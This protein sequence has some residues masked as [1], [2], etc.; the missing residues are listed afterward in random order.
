MDADDYD[1]AGLV[2]SLMKYSNHTI[3]DARV[4]QWSN[5]LF[6]HNEARRWKI[7]KWM[8][9][10]GMIVP[11]DGP[12]RREFPQ[13]TPYLEPFHADEKL[14]MF[15]L[16]DHGV[17]AYRIGLQ[18]FLRERDKIEAAPYRASIAAV[19]GFWVS[20]AALALSLI[21]IAISIIAL[22]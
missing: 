17:E 20:I 3:S 9:G 18:L 10:K 14:H 7:Y 2:L 8:M 13:V 4:V 15:S 5:D 11:D 22:S 12:P 6:A 16:T 1:F 19:R 21:G